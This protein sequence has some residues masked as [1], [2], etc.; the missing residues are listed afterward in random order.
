M[1]IDGRDLDVREESILVEQ[2]RKTSFVCHVESIRQELVVKVSNCFLQG[3]DVSLF[4]N[5]FFDSSFFS[6]PRSWFPMVNTEPFL[7]GQSV[8]HVVVEMILL[9]GCR[10]FSAWCIAERCVDT[11]YID[12][13]TPKSV[14]GVRFYPCRKTISYGRDVFLTTK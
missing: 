11:F 9:A 10:V 7:R 6:T 1:E 13:V 8:G 14:L 5:L 3:D 4:R 2:D 12:S